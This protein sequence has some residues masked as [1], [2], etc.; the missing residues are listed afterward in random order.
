MKF[1]YIKEHNINKI[2]YNLHLEN[3]SKWKRIWNMIYDNI[4]I[5]I[6]RK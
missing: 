6:E 3:A 4:E 5:D 2:L 1:L